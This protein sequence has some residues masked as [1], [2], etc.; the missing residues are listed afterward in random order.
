M[1]VG[2]TYTDLD[3]PDDFNATID[4][5]QAGS[6]DKFSSEN[7]KSAMSMYDFFCIICYQREQHTKRGAYIVIYRKVIRSPVAHPQQ[8]GQHQIKALKNCCPR[9]V[10]FM[11]SSS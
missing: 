6:D 8:M 5:I 2:H 7:I 4:A 11:T 10:N 9:T 1:R 3:T